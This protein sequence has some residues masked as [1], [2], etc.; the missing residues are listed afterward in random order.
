[1]KMLQP[2]SSTDPLFARRATSPPQSLGASSALTPIFRSVAARSCEALL[3]AGQ[4]VGWRMT[5]FS[6]AYPASLKSCL[7][8][9]GS[10]PFL[11]HPVFSSLE[12]G[13]SFPNIEVTV[14][15]YFGSRYDGAQERLLIDQVK[16]RLARLDVVERLLQKVHAQEHVRARLDP[17][18][19][20]Q[21]WD[22][23]R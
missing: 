12:Y 2:P 9:S 6:P 19:A 22:R 16:H 3:A 23:S 17:E 8:L 14:W 20:V 21:G 18:L 13:V 4:S 1:M 11:N 10:P 7:A 15:T 5:T